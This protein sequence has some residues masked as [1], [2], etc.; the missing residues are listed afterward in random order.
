MFATL[1]VKPSS[2]KR[3]VAESQK[4]H[5]VRPFAKVWAYLIL[6]THNSQKPPPP[7]GFQIDYSVTKADFQIMTNFSGVSVITEFSCCR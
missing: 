1:A 4:E 6:E 3:L 5:E 2:E 7:S